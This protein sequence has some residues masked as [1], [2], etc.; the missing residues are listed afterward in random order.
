M[1]LG[2]V[3][4][5]HSDIVRFLWVAKDLEIRQVMIGNSNISKDD[6]AYNGSTFK[7]DSNVKNED[8]TETSWG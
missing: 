7:E 1:Y 4:V 6:F 2:N 3:L 5:N 8:Q